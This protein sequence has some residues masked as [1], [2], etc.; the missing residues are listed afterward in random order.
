MWLSVG[1]EEAGMVGRLHK[2]K[3][4]KGL[5]N[6]PLNGWEKENE[7]KGRQTGAIREGEDTSGDEI[8]FI[9]LI[10]VTVSHPLLWGPCLGLCF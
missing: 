3:E 5:K 2:K 4:G 1:Q 8:V 7:F 6:A 10:N 9:G